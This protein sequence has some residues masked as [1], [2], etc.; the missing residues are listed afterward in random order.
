[1]IDDDLR[2]DHTRARLATMSTTL[3]YEED[4]HDG[5]LLDIVEELIKLVLHVVFLPVKILLAIV[6]AGV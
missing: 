2:I 1:M 6:S 4:D 5:S 3:C